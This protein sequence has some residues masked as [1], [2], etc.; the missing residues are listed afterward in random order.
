[1][2]AGQREVDIRI[3]QA[4]AEMVRADLM[5]ELPERIT[6]ALARLEI[7]VPLAG[8]MACKM[9]A[10]DLGDAIVKLLREDW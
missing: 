3:G 5:A 10:D 4:V 1:L 9:V 8:P 6:D 2:D 7:H